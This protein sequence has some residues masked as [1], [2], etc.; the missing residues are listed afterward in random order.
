MVATRPWLN[1]A[2][3]A[4]ILANTRGTRWLVGAGAPDAGDGFTD[5]IYLDNENGDYYQKVNSVTW[6]LIGSLAFPPDLDTVDGG[7][8]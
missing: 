2:A 3:R 8:Y 1:S 7:F 5:D 4:E 6:S